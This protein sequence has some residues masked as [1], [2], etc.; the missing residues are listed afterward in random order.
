[1]ESEFYGNFIVASLNHYA[2][3]IYVCGVRAQVY[4]SHGIAEHMGRYELLGQTLSENGILAEGHDHG[5]I[6]VD[7]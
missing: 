2:V 6:L 7:L 5:K 3:I 1:M 4:V